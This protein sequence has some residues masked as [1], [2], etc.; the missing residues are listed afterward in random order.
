MRRLKILTVFIVLFTFWT[1]SVFAAPYHEEPEW[2]K[3]E[4]HNVP[5]FVDSKGNPHQNLYINHNHTII[6]DTYYMKWAQPAIVFCAEKGYL[7]GMLSSKYFLS[8]Q[9]WIDKC[10]LAILLGRMEAIDYKKYTQEVFSDIKFSDFDLS[11]DY[12]NTDWYY[13]LSPYYINWAGKEGILQGTGQGLLGNNEITREH[14]AVMIDRY[15]EKYTSL[16]EGVNFSHTAVSFKDEDKIAGWAKES[17]RR[18]AAI[19]LING[20]HLGFYNPKDNTNRAQICQIIY[21]IAQRGN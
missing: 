2:V 7:D 21:N 16:Y 1:G 4:H 14:I 19:R 3:E 8:P 20:D 11:E 15:V 10:D 17:I 9:S 12:E 5:V 18:L 6:V 13:N